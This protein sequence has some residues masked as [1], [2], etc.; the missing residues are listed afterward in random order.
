MT[1]KGWLVCRQ[2]L[3]PGLRPTGAQRKVAAVGNGFYRSS[4]EPITH[5]CGHLVHIVDDI[6]LLR[7]DWRL[8][9]LRLQGWQKLLIVIGPDGPQRR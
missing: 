9:W 5:H 8:V 4:L 2:C 3:H 1:E 7:V 6:Q